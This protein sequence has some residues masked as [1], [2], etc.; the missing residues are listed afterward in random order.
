V[1][2]DF[3]PILSTNNRKTEIV[4]LANI[5]PSLQLDICRQA[6]SA[7]LIISDTMNLW[8]ANDP[9]G[10][11]EVLKKT[12]IFLLND[13]EAIQLTRQANLEDAAHWLLATGPAT[14]VIKQG[15]KGALVATNNSRQHVPVYPHARVVDP[16]GAG[17]SF[18]GGFIG[19]IAAQSKPDLVQAVIQGSAI[20]SFTV[21]GFGLEGLQLA[22]PER[23]NDRMT[24]IR[25]LM[26]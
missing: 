19:H 26:D 13:E 1:F 9:D 22:S 20:A 12:N 7:K 18:A 4:Y 5:Q 25:N 15:K 17:D 2:K 14:V 10:L 24:A 3:K 8:I 23:I 21:E 16:T 11:A 6:S